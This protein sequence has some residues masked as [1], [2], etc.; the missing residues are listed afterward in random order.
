[1]LRAPPSRGA[2]VAWPAC[3]PLI[4][5]LSTRRRHR[6]ARRILHGPASGL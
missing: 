6:F 2:L 4:A 3:D 1:M 5:P